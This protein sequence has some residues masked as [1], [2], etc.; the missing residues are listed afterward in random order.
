MSVNIIVAV[1]KNN[2]IGGD[3]HRGVPVIPWKS[4]DDMRFFKEETIGH[5][6]IMGRRTFESLPPS[7]RPL[8][9]RRNIVISSSM[10]SGDIEGVTV[11]R[12]ISEA[13]SYELPKADQVFIIGGEEIYKEAIYFT[14][15]IYISTIMEDYRPIEVDTRELSNVK[16]FP[17][18]DDSSFRIIRNR[19]NANLDIKVYQRIK[20][21]NHV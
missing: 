16:R 11:Y 13:L 19:V 9:D 3:N 8:P 4:P 7:V 1:D 5:T 21:D 15:N 20:N 14:D 10:S 6:V 17:I 2:V 12:S 18:I